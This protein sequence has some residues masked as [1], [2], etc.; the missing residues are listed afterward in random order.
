MYHLLSF[1]WQLILILGIF[2]LFLESSAVP[3][4]GGRCGPSHPGAPRAPVSPPGERQGND[5]HTA[6]PGHPRGV[7]RANPPDIDRSSSRAGRRLEIFVLISVLFLFLFLFLFWFFFVLFQIPV[8]KYIINKIYD[9]IDR[10]IIYC[11][12]QLYGSQLFT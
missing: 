3:V 8:L 1:F 11:A 2:W 9:D 5:D 4:P 12:M 6:P 7:G 10:V